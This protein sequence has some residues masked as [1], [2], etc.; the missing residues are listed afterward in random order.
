MF[1]LL[2]IAWRN[3]GRNRRRSWL[4]ALAIGFAVAILIFAMAL[5]QGSYA[6]MIFNTVHARTGNLQLQHPAY[7]PDMDLAK[8]LARPGE[9]TPLL[10]SLPQVRAYTPRIQAAALVSTTNRTFGALLQ[11]I[12]PER[13]AETSTL[14]EVVRTGSYLTP[15]DRDGA[16]VGERLARNLGAGLGDELVFLGQGADGSLAAGTL[17]IRG[18]FKTG[19]AEI[20]RQAVAAHIDTIREAFSMREGVTEI[21]VLLH[22]D[23]DRPAVAARLREAIAERGRQD[24]A[25]VVEWTTLMPGVEESIQLDWY[26]GQIIYLV[27]VLV[28]GFGIANTFLMAY[29]ERIH[30]FGVLLSLGMRPGRLS[31]MVYAES[32]FLILIGAGLGLGIGIPITQFFHLHGIRFGEG[33]E[34]L[35]AEYGM[36]ATI[37]PLI[38]PM[39]LL[40]AVGIVLAVSLAL[41]AYP[42]WK[43]SRLLP[44]EGLRHR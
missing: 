25:A 1:S 21:A 6:D 18:L 24:A 30:E 42:A 4:T 44:V 16:L 35:M 28:V 32:V 10:E 14:N 2:H 12:D 13:E 31:G 15:Q 34:E 27:L 19:I 8:R 37:H 23:R 40:L 7:W 33:A 9:W 43:S 20:D 22:R 3:I 26:S 41:A 39:V 38:T 29:M 17:I 5:Q 11:G 36:S